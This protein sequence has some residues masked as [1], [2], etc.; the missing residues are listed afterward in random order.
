MVSVIHLYPRN[1]H[2]ILPKVLFR[3]QGT[4]TVRYMQRRETFVT[5][6]HPWSLNLNLSKNMVV[7]GYKLKYLSLH[8]FPFFKMILCHGI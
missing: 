8:T 3:T 2:N 4:Y 6:S 7:N 1:L 5:L